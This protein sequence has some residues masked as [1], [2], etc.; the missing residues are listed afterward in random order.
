M[1]TAWTAMD[2]AWTAMDTAWTAMDMAW[3]AR[4]NEAN[5]KDES[6]MATLTAA[7]DQET[8]SSLWRASSKSVCLH[9]DWSL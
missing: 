6:T 8:P 5:M 4:M 7:T 1:D 2:T 9:S 3:T